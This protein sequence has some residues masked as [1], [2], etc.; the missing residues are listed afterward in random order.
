M[1]IYQ[2]YCIEDKLE[3]ALVYLVSLKFLFGSVNQFFTGLYPFADHNHVGSVK[4]KHYPHRI[5]RDFISTV[6]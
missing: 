6:S 2:C 1:L 4:P 3:L 5:H